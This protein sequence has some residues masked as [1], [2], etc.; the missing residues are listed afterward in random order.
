MVWGD[1]DKEA[2]TTE[3]KDPNYLLEHMFKDS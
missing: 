3:D 1:V 2:A